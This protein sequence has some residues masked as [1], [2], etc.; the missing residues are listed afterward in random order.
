ME[1]NEHRG[2]PRERITSTEQNTHFLTKPSRIVDTEIGRCA[3]S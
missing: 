2:K 3:V 1:D